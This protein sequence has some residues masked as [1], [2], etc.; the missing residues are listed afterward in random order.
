MAAFFHFGEQ[1]LTMCVKERESIHL[2]C[3]SYPTHLLK[4]HGYP[5][6]K[7]ILDQ[8]SLQ[9][10][11]RYTYVGKIKAESIQSPLDKLNW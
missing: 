2:M 3:H 7:G 6:Y 9:M 11:M 4:G 8:K 1:R 5:E 10:M